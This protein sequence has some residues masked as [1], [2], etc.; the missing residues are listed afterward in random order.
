MR[1]AIVSDI[2]GNRTAFDAVVSDL[3]QTAPDVVLHGG[4]LADVG[5]HPA[6]IVDRIRDLGW[7]GV[8]GNTDEMLCR[9]ESLTEYASQFPALASLFTAVEEMAVATRLALGRERLEW[10]GKLPRIH[11]E[12]PLA[13]VHASPATPWR[14]PGAGS[15]DAELEAIFGPLGCSVAVFGHIHHPFIRRIGT[16]TVANCGSVGMSYDGDRRAA[17]LLVDDETPSIRRVEYDVETEVQAVRC[18]G[19]PHADWVA[20]VLESA[21]PQMP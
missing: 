6:E 10:L 2:H 15:T 4:D 20:R 1:I 12:G 21:G 3:R 14:S 8:R 9:P 16:L 5:P 13:L 11:R 18:C 7:H 17:Y 19:W